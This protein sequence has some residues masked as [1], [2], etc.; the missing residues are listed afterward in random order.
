[1]GGGK[2]LTLEVSEILAEKPVMW[3]GTRL[4]Q[5]HMLEFPWYLI[6]TS[7]VSHAS[8]NKVGPATEDGGLPLASWIYLGLPR[9]TSCGF[10]RFSS[11]CYKERKKRG[12][13]DT[14][15]PKSVSPDP[16]GGQHGKPPIGSGASQV[17]V[18]GWARP[19]PWRLLRSLPAAA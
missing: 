8:G 5:N 19:W 18:L 10:C 13:T 14:T 6:G 12:A 7:L 17:P 11:V 16:A 3:F 9:K 1:M 4:T 15:K 2:S